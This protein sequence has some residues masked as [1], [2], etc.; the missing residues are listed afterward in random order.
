MEKE[1]A[2]GVSVGW[3]TYISI[4]HRQEEQSYFEEKLGLVPG[5]K[6]NRTLGWRKESSRRGNVKRG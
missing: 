6:G 4:L 5:M 1:V 2:G 3:N